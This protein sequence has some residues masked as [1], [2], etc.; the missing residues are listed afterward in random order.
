MKLLPYPFSEWYYHC[1]HW[2]QRLRGEWRLAWDV[3]PTC[4][5]DAP[6]CDHCP[7]CFGSRDYPLSAETKDIY[8]R[9]YLAS[10]AYRRLRAGEIIR[11]GDEVDACADGWRDA[12]RWQ[13]AADYTIG[14]PAPDPRYPAHRQYRRKCC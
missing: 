10:I 4:N 9:S 1:R 14:K 5:S 6:E 8:R 2:L 12:P 3:C 13:P 7:T 11:P